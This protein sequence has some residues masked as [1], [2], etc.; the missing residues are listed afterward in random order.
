MSQLADGWRSMKDANAAI[1]E[2]KALAHL[3]DALAAISSGTPV[4]E[5]SSERDAS[6]PVLR[7]ILHTGRASTEEVCSEIQHIVRR[8]S[9]RYG[10]RVDMRVSERSRE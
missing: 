2:G 8:V 9:D 6:D 10:V 7:L 1:A 4:L 5:I 3:Q